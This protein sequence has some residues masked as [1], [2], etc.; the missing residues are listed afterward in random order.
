MLYYDTEAQRQ[1]AKER[2]ADLTRV[3]ERHR[4][5]WGAIGAPSR[6]RGFIALVTL[7]ISGRGASAARRGAV[8]TA[9]RLTARPGG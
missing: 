7:L 9:R 4:V 3:A 8:L 5:A 6:R 1:F 2:I